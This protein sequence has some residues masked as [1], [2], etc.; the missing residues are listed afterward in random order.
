MKCSN[1][2]ERK[3]STDHLWNYQPGWYEDDC[4]SLPTTTSWAPTQKLMILVLDSRWR[5]NITMNFTHVLKRLLYLGVIKYAWEIQLKH[6]SNRTIIK[7]AV[8]FH[9]QNMSEQIFRSILLCTY[10]VHMN[11]YMYSCWFFPIF[12]T[13]LH[14]YPSTASAEACWRKT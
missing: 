7:K 9:C 2:P 1:R 8:D 5:C 4:S 14:L 6:Y 12:I 13:K 10:A 11:V 3:W